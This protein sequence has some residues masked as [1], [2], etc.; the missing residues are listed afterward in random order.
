MSLISANMLKCI[1]SIGY[2]KRDDQS[3]VW[4]GTGFLYGDFV[5]VLDETTHQY[6]NYLVTNN[7]VFNAIL[8]EGYLKCIVQMNPIGTDQAIVFDCT[9]GDTDLKP[10]WTI[11]DDDNIDLAIIKINPSV[12]KI[13]NIEHF[14]FRSDIDV[15]FK[16][17]MINEHVCEGDDVIVMGFP[18][19]LVDVFRSYPIARGGIIARIQDTKIGISSTFLVDVQIYPGNSGGPV[20]LRV[21]SDH[22]TGTHP[23]NSPKLIGIV[24]QYIP[25]RDYAKSMQTGSILMVSEENSGLAVVEVCDSLKSIIEKHSRTEAENGNKSL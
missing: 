4:C 5:K 20:I 21:V 19:G 16:Q 8:L 1:V 18:M 25:Y 9:I 7:H 24:K 6:D 14:I 13:N 15:L 10:V 11:H 3:A 2:R 12:L 22:L 23:H 17:D